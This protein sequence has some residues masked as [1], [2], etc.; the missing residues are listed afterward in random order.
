MILR[1]VVLAMALFPCP[2]CG[3]S[4]SSL[5]AACPHCGCP[6]SRWEEDRYALLLVG[7]SDP[8]NIHQQEVTE[9]LRAHFSLSDE[10]I[11]T[12]AALAPGAIFPLAA[13]LDYTAAWTLVRR[14]SPATQ[15]RC[16][17]LPAE[18]AE[19]QTY[20]KEA[21]SAFHLLTKKST[22]LFRT[23]LAAVLAALGIFWLLLFLLSLL[24]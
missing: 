14:L 22:R 12:A 16:C 21:P 6:H 5:A 23:I 17:I 9:E 15:K 24:L 11:T 13:G 1:K 7:G 20:L 2:E 4:L 8:F 19:D 18:L 3:Q 10:D